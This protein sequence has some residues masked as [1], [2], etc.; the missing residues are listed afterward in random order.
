[1]VMP[2]R[3][4][5]LLMAIGFLDLMMTAVLHHHGLIIELN[6]LMRPLI[7]RSEWLFAIVK[8]A[9]L[10]AAWWAMVKYAKTNVLFV[11]QAALLGSCAYLLVWNVW[12]WT[13][14]I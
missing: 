2:T 1:M 5:G 8:G 14:H 11:R 12:F 9:T 3:A 7:E 13:S 10:V 6:P 4:I